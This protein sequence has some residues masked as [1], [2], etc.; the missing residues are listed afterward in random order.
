MTLQK[1]VTRVTRPDIVARQAPRFLSL[2]R[3]SII[4]IVYF[5]AGEP[6][7]NTETQ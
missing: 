6:S 5:F 2:S 4:L 7:H 3:Q 1:A